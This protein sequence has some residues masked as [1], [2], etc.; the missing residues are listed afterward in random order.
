MALQNRLETCRNAGSRAEITI[1][2]VKKLSGSYL[3]MQAF[4]D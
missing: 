2:H 3:T 4:G 1:G